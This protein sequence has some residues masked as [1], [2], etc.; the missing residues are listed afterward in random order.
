MKSKDLGYFRE[1]MLPLIEEAYEASFKALCNMANVNP[2]KRMCVIHEG[3]RIL[4]LENCNDRYEDYAEMANIPIDKA[5]TRLFQ[6]KNFV[7]NY[8]RRKVREL[9]TEELAET[10]NVLTAIAIQAEEIAIGKK[11]GMGAKLP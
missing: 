11:K 9:K 5:K 4:H 7:L 1:L 10:Y 3:A 6:N 8:G 2:Y